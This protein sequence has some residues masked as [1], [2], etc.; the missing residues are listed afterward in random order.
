M[1][2]KNPAF[3]DYELFLNKYNYD[4]HLCTKYK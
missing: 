3:E 1:L 2:S 4:I